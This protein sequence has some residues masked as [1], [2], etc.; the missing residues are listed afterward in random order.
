MGGLPHHPPSSTANKSANLKIAH[1]PVCYKETAA[2]SN[3][4]GPAYPKTAV[5]F[6]VANAGVWVPKAVSLT[7]Q[8]VLCEERVL[9]SARGV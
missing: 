8:A 3:S 1:F 6:F 9:A 7:G 4:A 2:D 5:L